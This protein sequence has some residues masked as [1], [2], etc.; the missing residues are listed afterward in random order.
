[1]RLD[2]CLVEGDGC[3]GFVRDKNERKRKEKWHLV[4]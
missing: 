3:I 2:V 4:R 1:M